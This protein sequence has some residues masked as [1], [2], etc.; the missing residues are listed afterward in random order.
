MADPKFITFDAIIDDEKDKDIAQ[1]EQPAFIVRG[2][3][4]IKA[5]SDSKE[6]AYGTFE[7]YSVNRLLSFRLTSCEVENKE[8]DNVKLISSV[9]FPGEVNKT[10]C[11]S[12]GFYLNTNSTRPVILNCS[13]EK[14]NLNT[15]ILTSVNEKEKLT[16]AAIRAILN[17]WF[18][19]Q[20]D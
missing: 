19:L 2:N 8:F 6:A 18:F 7:W 9:K 10:K 14:E 12:L 5:G 4:S 13:I 3:G 11:S 16:L 1:V 20:L 17:K 15:L